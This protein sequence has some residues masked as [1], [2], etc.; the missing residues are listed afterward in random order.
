MYKKTTEQH[1]VTEVGC[2]LLAFVS[3]WPPI[4]PRVVPQPVGRAPP[5]ALVT[6]LRCSLAPPSQFGPEPV[7][8][9]PTAGP[10]RFLPSG[11]GLQSPATNPT[12]D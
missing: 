9:V 10:R 4:L 5:D 7:L 1:L 6:P 12:P 11:H 2:L 3:Q 8:H